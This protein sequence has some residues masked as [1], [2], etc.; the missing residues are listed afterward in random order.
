[1]LNPWPPRELLSPQWKTIIAA[2]MPQENVSPSYSVEMKENKNNLYSIHL[3]YWNQRFP[4]ERRSFPSNKQ[5]AL[6]NT[7]WEAYFDDGRK[8]RGLRGFIFR[9]TRHLPDGPVSDLAFLKNNHI[10]AVLTPLV[11][12]SKDAV[13]KGDGDVQNNR[14]K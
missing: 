8:G 5:L 4:R 13:K 6:I 12:K 1:V 11:R 9:Q 14:N 10:A 3:N 2:A 7:L